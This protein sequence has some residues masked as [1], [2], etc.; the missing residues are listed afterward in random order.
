MQ[1]N[2]KIANLRAHFQI[3]DSHSDGPLVPL[4][5]K[6]RKISYVP[7]LP[8]LESDSSQSPPT[9]AHTSTVKMFREITSLIQDVKKQLHSVQSEGKEQRLLKEVL[10]A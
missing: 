7:T 8:G 9:C 1:R 4:V 3:S 6:K 5:R 2:L 10:L